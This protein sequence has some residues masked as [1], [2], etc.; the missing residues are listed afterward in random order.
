MKDESGLSALHSA[1]TDASNVHLLKIGFEGL[2][3]FL[4][5]TNDLD[6]VLRDLSEMD[7]ANTRKSAIALQKQLHALEPSVT[8]VGPK[9]FTS[10]C[11]SLDLG[12]DIFAH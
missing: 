4:A 2:E 5:K 9:S 6:S 8:M 1:A 7:D 11:Q 10:G 3:G 12:R